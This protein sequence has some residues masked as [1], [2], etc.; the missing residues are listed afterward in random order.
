MGLHSEVVIVRVVLDLAFLSGLAIVNRGLKF[1]AHNT[2]FC[3]NTLN[4]HKF[5]DQVRFKS[6]RGHIVLTNITLK[7]DIVVLSFD[8]ERN[9]ILLLLHSIGLMLTLEALDHTVGDFLKD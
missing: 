6:A 2:H 1:I 5:V 8:W 9:I 4:L 3:H 7:V